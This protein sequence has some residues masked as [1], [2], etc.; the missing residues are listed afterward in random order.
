[1]KSALPENRRQALLFLPG[2]MLFAVAVYYGLE[3]LSYGFSFLDEGFHM[4]DSWRLWAGDHF[5]DDQLTRNH[6]LYTLLNRLVFEISPEITLLGMRRLAYGLNLLTLFA[7]GFAL[8]QTTGRYWYLPYVFSL[9]VFTGADPIGAFSSLNYYSYPNLFLTFFLTFFLLGLHCRSIPARRAWLT[10][11]GL[12]LWLISLSLLHL[13]LIA[14]T[15]LIYYIFLKRFETK[16][17]AIAP[18]DLLCLLGP[19][20]LLWFLFYIVY[21][22]AFPLSVLYAVKIST[23][24]HS[25]GA[26]LT[27]INWQAVIYMTGTGLFLSGFAIIIRFTDAAGRR[28]ILLYAAMALFSILMF[29]IV[30]TSFFGH[31]RPYYNGWFGR[32]M[33]FAS[34]IS[35]LLLA[36]FLYFSFKLAKKKPCLAIDELPLILFVPSAIFAVSTSI[37]SDFGILSTLHCAVPVCVAVA[38]LL[39]K[40]CESRLIDGAKTALII[41]LFFFPFYATSSWADWRFTYFDVSPE[42]ADTI[43]ESGFG[44]GIKTNPQYARLY[45]WIQTNTVKYSTPD[46]YMI[47]YTLSPMSYMIAKRKPALDHTW[48]C[49]YNFPPSFYKASIQ[50][51]KKAGRDPKI[52]FIF[53]NS[54]AFSPITLKGNNYSWMWKQFSFESSRDPITEYVKAHMVE[55][56]RLR[57]HDNLTAL[58][59]VAKSE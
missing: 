32:Q 42:T 48:T 7:F 33:W 58:C 43:L 29:F 47:S 59:F 53:E 35:V 56:D 11:S 14:A 54:P 40:W 57:L 49:F 26:A 3:K 27:K 52:V 9:F 46:D 19:F 22:N 34:M 50:K 13:S 17:S 38:Y 10:A 31:I 20:V 37:F 21:G 25:P 4:A 45:R 36:F 18:A 41:V 28:G 30:D 39:E 2:A 15:P 44:K 1:M 5:L 6:M 16:T 55:V 51:M 12:S 23:L 8:F 24:D